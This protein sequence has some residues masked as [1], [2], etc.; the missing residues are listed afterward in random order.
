MINTQ[1][2][3][4]GLDKTTVDGFAEALLIAMSNLRDDQ[5]RYLGVRMSDDFDE[6]IRF[7]K[8]IA[9]MMLKASGQ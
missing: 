5:G 1:D 2:L 4:D 7:A 3:I 8:D 9:K 6:H